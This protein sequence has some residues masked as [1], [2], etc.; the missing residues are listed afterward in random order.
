[1]NAESL[2]VCS[3]GQWEVGS[4]LGREGHGGLISRGKQEIS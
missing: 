3:L 1:M 4:V 2:K